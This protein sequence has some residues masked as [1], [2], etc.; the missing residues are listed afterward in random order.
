MNTREMADI[1]I[2]KYIEERRIQKPQWKSEPKFI[3][4]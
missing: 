1:W 2:E 3:S 4:T